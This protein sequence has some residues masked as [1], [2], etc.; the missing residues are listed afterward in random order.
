MG[1]IV[2]SKGPYLAADAG[3]GAGVAGVAAEVHPVPRA[4]KGP[5]APERRVP[6]QPPPGEVP[7]FGA[8]QCQFTDVGLFV[9]VQL[10]DPFLWDPPAAKVGADPQR[11]DEGRG[12]GVQQLTNGRQVEMVVMIMGDDN[13]V[14]DRQIGQRKRHRMHPRRADELGRRH[15]VPPDRVGQHVVTVQF[16]QRG[17]MPEPGHA[18]VG[19]L[20]CRD[21]RDQ[22][23]RTLRV[24]AIAPGDEFRDQAE[25]VLADDHVGRLGVVETGVGEVR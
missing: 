12:L 4:G 8:G 11:N 24:P 17:R 13:G 18:Q 19:R 15:P 10:D 2:T 21:R 23:Y 3:E 7:G 14:Q 25:H 16:D 22:G 9:P 20:H 5:G 6:A 1:R